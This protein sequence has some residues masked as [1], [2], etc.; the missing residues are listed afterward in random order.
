MSQAGLEKVLA[1]VKVGWRYKGK[2]YDAKLEPILDLLEWGQHAQGLKLLGP[3]RKSPTKAL[4]ESANKLYDAVKEEG[5]E[6]VAEAEKLAGT[7]PVR[8]Y[9]LYAKVA[10]VFG[11][12]SWA[13]RWP[14]R[15]R[16]WRPTRWC[17]R[18]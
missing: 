18:S 17:S 14:S 9:D 10:A 15:S 7:D 4:A 8:A 6:W 11:A 2:G 5:Q 3:Q 12:T 16:S 13:S 1:A